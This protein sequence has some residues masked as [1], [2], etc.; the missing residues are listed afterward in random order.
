MRPAARRRRRRASL[1]RLSAPVARAAGA[2]RPASGRRDGDGAAAASASRGALRIAVLVLVLVVV[3]VVT[4]RAKSREGTQHRIQPHLGL[5]QELR[6]TC[7]RKDAFSLLVNDVHTRG[8]PLHNPGHHPALPRLR[9]VVHLL[10][11]SVATLQVRARSATRARTGTESGGATSRSTSGLL[12]GLGRAAAALSATSAEGQEATLRP[13]DADDRRGCA[14]AC[15]CSLSAVARPQGPDEKV[16]L[17]ELVFVHD[18]NLGPVDEDGALGDAGHPVSRAAGRRGRG[19]VEHD[20]F[21]FH[22]C[23]RSDAPSMM[24]R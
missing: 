13:A 6:G 24:R 7:L 12:R 3:V 20:W 10:A 17:V 5:G 15:R 23:C 4:F 2:S 21:V 16:D 22:V 18:G 11:D 1:R 9:E 14:G 8:L 19:G